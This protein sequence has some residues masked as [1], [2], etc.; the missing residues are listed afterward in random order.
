MIL[1]R[2]TIPIVAVAAIVVVA[3]AT[4][5]LAAARM[6]DSG[7]AAPAQAPTALPNDPGPVMSPK[8][9]TQPT[10]KPEADLPFILDLDSPIEAAADKSTMRHS[11]E[12]GTA[13]S[14]GSRS[15]GGGSGQAGPGQGTVYTWQDG[16]RTRRVVL[17]D[18][19]ESPSAAPDT[20]SYTPNKPSTNESLDKDGRIADPVFRP[21]SGG[22][23]MMLPGGIILALEPD[24][25]KA[26]VEAYFSENGIAMDRVKKL[27]FID[28]GFAVE[29]EP[30]FPSLDLA[31]E[32]AEQDGVLISSP[33]WWTDVEAK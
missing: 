26:T 3:G 28:N 12:G 8:P 6:Q 30:G 31:N 15:D 29:T 27:D 20:K 21:E 11:K 17:L 14:K 18:E 16:D 5:G 32:L 4:A 9:E 33:N 23:L 7:P 1:G 2:F 22:G 13:S 19:A 24:W 25:D 10:R